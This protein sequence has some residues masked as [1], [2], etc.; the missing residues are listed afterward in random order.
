MCISQ[1]QQGEFWVVECEIAKTY[2][3]Q[4]IFSQST[5]ASGHLINHK[6]GTDKLGPQF[7]LLKIVF[8]S[9]KSPADSLFIL[10]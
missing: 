8:D 7:D 4:Q 3:L 5:E 6:N 2:L 9:T 1:R 10:I